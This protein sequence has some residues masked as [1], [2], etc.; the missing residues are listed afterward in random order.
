[1]TA[2]KAVKAPNY[3]DEQVSQMRDLFAEGKT[4]DEIAA[5][6]GKAKKSIVA[7]AS[8]EGF[9]VKPEKPAKVEKDDGPT[10]KEMLAE[11]RGMVAF[12]V[13]GLMNAT[14]EAI[15]GLIDHLKAQAESEDTTAE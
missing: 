14:K 8:R 5:I 13:D 11:L 7:K 10:K 4:A 1:M 3:T 9:Y 2:T 6:M 15:Q 12:D